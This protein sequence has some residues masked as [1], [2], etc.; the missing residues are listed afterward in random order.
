M[1][2]SEEAI[3]SIKAALSTYDK[4]CSEDYWQFDLDLKKY[5]GTEAVFQKHRDNLAKIVAEFPETIRKILKELPV[6]DPAS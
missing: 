6:Y 4:A 5:G 3:A 2:T 1:I